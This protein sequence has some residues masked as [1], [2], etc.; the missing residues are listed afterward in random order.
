LYSASALLVYDLY[1]YSINY[2]LLLKDDTKIL[3]ASVEC[4][5]RQA[6]RNLY[7]LGTTWF[8][9]QTATQ[10]NTLDA[11]RTQTEILTRDTLILRHIQP[12]LTGLRMGRSPI[13]LSGSTESMK[14]MQR[15]YGS[16]VISGKNQLTSLPKKVQEK[17]AHITKDMTSALL[18]VVKT[19][20]LIGSVSFASFAASALITSVGFTA[21]AMTGYYSILAI[22]FYDIYLAARNLDSLHHDSEIDL[23]V[24][25]ELRQLFINVISLIGPDI[26]PD[27]SKLDAANTKAKIITKDTIILRLFEGIIRDLILCDL[28]LAFN[29]YKKLATTLLRIPSY[30]VIYGAKYLDQQY[31]VKEKLSRYLDKSETLYYVA[32]L[33]VAGFVCNPLG[34]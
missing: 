16:I 26:S 6:V 1:K 15:L 34:S 17:A 14:A 20:G 9:G 7:Y 24:N 10:S 19:A 3:D 2:C 22:L 28:S 4:E 21:I 11:A 27:H 8:T 29:R 30:P 13:D 12:V 18:A 33:K 32:A 23:S 5:M 25:Y 31:H